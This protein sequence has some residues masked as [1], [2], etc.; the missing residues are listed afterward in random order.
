MAQ[1]YSIPESQAQA[2]PKRRSPVLIWL[3]RLVVGAALIVLLFMQAKA[4][5][6][7]AQH[8]PI[9]LNDPYT[10][11]YGEGPLL[12]QAVR[13]ARGENIYQA[14]LSTPP[15]TITN[16]PPLYMLA[17]VPFVQ[18]FGAAF[19]YGRLISLIS[20]LVAAL[21][22]ALT[23]QAITKDWLAGLVAG[24]ILPAIPYIYYWSAL[25]RIDSL[26]LALSMAGL[27]V[28][29]RGYQ[30]RWALILAVLLLTAAAYTRQTYLL[31]APLAGFIYV[32]S[33]GERFK[34]VMF[35]LL[36]GCVVL[37]IFAVVLV[38]TRGGIFFH[39]ITANVNALNPDLIT[40]YV[41]ELTQNFPILLAAGAI[42]LILG[43]IF[44][45]P[46]YWLIAPYILGAVAVA[47]TISKVGSDVNYLFELSAAFCFAAGGVIAL[48]RRCATFG[49]ILRAGALLL[50]ALAVSMATTLTSTNYY[51]ILRV[52]AKQASQM[53]QLVNVIR[54]TDKPILADEEMGLLALNGKPILFQPFEMSQLAIAGL[55]N[56]QPFLDALARGDYPIILLYQ[57][58]RN[59]ELRF[60]RWTPEMLRIINDDFRPD[61]QSAET[62]VYRYAGP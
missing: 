56:Q 19:W 2:E 24:L 59:P 9:A 44:G 20:I 51:E 30:R 17:Q 62:T 28:I 42:Y 40:H 10:L 13:L 50:I 36:L 38:A 46:A 15:Y 61:F 5:I 53:G 34:A 7:Y 16:Y 39:I 25:A 48:T 52:S 29:V 8:I 23:V 45:R 3:S 35:A 43:A 33:R 27:C 22:L 60:E 21:L 4:L 1:L 37:A 12:D 26:A 57:P 58:A 18:Q 54:S 41:N 49:C 47:L 55:W 14:D 6:L 32:W 31:T 11:N